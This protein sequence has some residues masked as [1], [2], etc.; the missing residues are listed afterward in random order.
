MDKIKARKKSLKRDFMKYF[1]LC[2]IF[3]FLGGC[4]IAVLLQ[5]ELAA[6]YGEAAG[7][8]ADRRFI[9]HEVSVL[10]IAAIALWPITCVVGGT[11]LYK[12]KLEKHIKIL[13]QGI[14]SSIAIRTCIYC[15]CNSD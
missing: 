6:K 2:V 15:I 14:I 11:V 1:A 4:L 12:R 8:N 13:T 10:H 5:T 9:Y 7:N 3:V